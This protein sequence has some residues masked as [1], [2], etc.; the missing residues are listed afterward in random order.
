MIQHSHELNNMVHRNLKLS[1]FP[2]TIERNHCLWKV[3]YC[4]FVLPLQ[5]AKRITVASD[6]KPEFLKCLPAFDMPSSQWISS[7][8]GVPWNI[9]KILQ[10]RQDSWVFDQQFQ[11]YVVPHLSCPNGTTIMHSAFSSMIF[12]KHFPGSVLVDVGSRVPSSPSEVF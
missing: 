1:N 11:N 5:A 8:D 4:F 10:L 2:F 6:E 12:C 9:H 7:K 3:L